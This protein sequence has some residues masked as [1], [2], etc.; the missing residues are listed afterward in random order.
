MGRGQATQEY[1]RHEFFLGT[2]AGQGVARRLDPA[3]T[4]GDRSAFG[5]IYVLRDDVL[6]SYPGVRG[7]GTPRRDRHSI[8]TD[9]GGCLLPICGRAQRAGRATLRPRASSWSGLN[10]SKASWVGSI[11]QDTVDGHF[12]GPIEAEAGNFEVAEAALLDAYE[13]MMARGER[14]SPQPLPGTWALCT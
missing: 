10:K 12:L 8:F 6:G 4:T 14:G 7:P 2:L 1:A 9:I 5:D 3:F 13:R 11:L